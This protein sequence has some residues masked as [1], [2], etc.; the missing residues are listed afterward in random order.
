MLEKLRKML[1]GKEARKVSLV[2]QAKKTEDIQELRN[3]NAELESLNGEIGELRGLITDAEKQQ[4]VEPEFRSEKGAPVVPEGP[5]NPMATYTSKE[6]RTDKDPLNTIEYRNA[7]MEFAKTGKVTPELREGTEPTNAFSGVADLTAVVPTTILNEV[8]RELKVRGNVFGR[9]RKT[10]IK[11]GLQVPILSLKPVA[12]WIGDGESGLRQKVQAKTNV[13]FT[14]HGLEVKVATSL[15]AETVTLDSF[16]TTLIDLIVEAM[17]TALDTAVFSG[18]GNGQP[19]GIINDTRVPEGNVVTLNSEE[20]AKWDEWKKKVFA[21]MPLAYKAGAAFYMASG[22]FEG[23]IDGMV[24]KNGQPV[25]RV[26]YGIANGPQE[27]FGGKEVILV[28]D[29]IIANY[30]DATAATEL[31]DG[32]VVAIYADLGNYVINSNMQLAMFR[33]LDHDTNQYVDKAIMIADG[34]LLDPHGVV[35]VRKGA[36]GAEDVNP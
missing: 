3:I 21:K 29:D 15:I 4:T 12:T 26:N 27:R 20:F 16:E 35:I 13:S 31:I 1:E 7:F 10:S 33:Y 5:V 17:V 24:D 8:I 30:D 25:G 11:G 36:E 6:D 19:L 18:S 32:D 22:T 28:E 14:Y 23:Y 9:V 34:K 2:D